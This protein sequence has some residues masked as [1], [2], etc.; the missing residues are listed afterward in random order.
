M[1]QFLDQIR[2]ALVTDASDAARTAGATACRTILAV[3]DAKPG[4]PMHVSD[5][6]TASHSSTTPLLAAMPPAP[7]TTQSAGPRTSPAVT[8]QALLAALR[9]M[10]ADQLLD[11]AITRLRAAV[12][13]GESVA[14]TQG[15]RF[16]LIPL[17][18]TYGST[19][20]TR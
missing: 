20:G 17:G 18:A 11:L 8:V 10:P 16:H 2:A 4:E 9:G 15:L 5:A 1:E 19:A 3:L 6:A 13:G 12:P 14:P 7:H